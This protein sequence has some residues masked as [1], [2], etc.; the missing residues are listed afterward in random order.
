MAEETQ[1]EEV[2]E[3][4]EETSQEEKET[5]QYRHGLPRNRKI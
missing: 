1:T 2:Q 5:V 3:V 4:E